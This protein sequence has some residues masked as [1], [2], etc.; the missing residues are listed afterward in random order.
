MAYKAVIS[1]VDTHHDRFDVT[2]DVVENDEVLV[3]HT[4][5]FPRVR[6]LVEEEGTDFEVD[7]ETDERREVPV[8]R[9]LD[10]G[11]WEW[12]APE[13]VHEAI[14]NYLRDVVP[15]LVTEPAIAAG[16]EVI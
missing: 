1:R 11:E 3:T 13:V 6:S 15:T 14:Q 5:G 10:T 9:S 16:H 7:P 12:T 8:T 2:F 4:Q